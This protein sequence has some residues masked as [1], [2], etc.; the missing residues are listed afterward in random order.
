[1]FMTILDASTVAADFLAVATISNRGG[2]IVTCSPI[3][4]IPTAEMNISRSQVI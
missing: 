2:C 1:M 4:A 3:G